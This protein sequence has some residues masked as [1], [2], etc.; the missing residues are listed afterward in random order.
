MSKWLHQTLPLLSPSTLTRSCSPLP[1]GISW[2]LQKFN[3]WETQRWKDPQFAKRVNSAY[4]T[5]QTMVR[6]LHYHNH[7]RK[8]HYNNVIRYKKLSQHADLCTLFIFH[9]YSDVRC[10]DALATSCSSFR[11]L[12]EVLAV[13]PTDYSFTQDTG[14]F[15]L[16]WPDMLHGSFPSQCVTG[17]CLNST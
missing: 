1:D 17:D 15:H 12:S 8:Q 2:T 14:I 5:K 11:P 4:A 16:S 6:P 3:M 9:G 13:A 10:V 7:V